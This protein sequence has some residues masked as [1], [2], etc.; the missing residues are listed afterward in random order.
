MSLS[1]FNTVDIIEVMENAIEKMRPPEDIRDKLDLNYRIENQSIILCEVRPKFNDPKTKM[2]F[3]FA[4]ATF[5]KTT[6]KWR[7]YWMRG[8]LK[9]SLYDPEKEVDNLH[10]FMRIIQEDKYHCFFG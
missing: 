7:I 9:W 8:N 4:K 5:V 6:N 10:E 2:E 3:A 1:L